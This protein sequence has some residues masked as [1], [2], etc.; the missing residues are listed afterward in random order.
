MKKI[1]AVILSGVFIF[2]LC[3]CKNKVENERFSEGS[4]IIT[5]DNLPKIAVTEANLNIAVNLVSA[6]L[7]CDVKD[8]ESLVFVCKTPDECYRKLAT[9]ESEIVIAHEPSGKTLEFLAQEQVI[10]QSSVI[11]NDA[12]VFT[13]SAQNPVSNLTIEQIKGIYSGEVTDWSSVS[14]NQG[15]IKPFMQGENSAAADAFNGCLNVDTSSLAKFFKSITT[16][17]GTFSIPLEF[18]NG[19]FSIGYAL[20]YDMLT[21]SADKNGKHKLLSVDGVLPDGSTVQSGT[22]PLLTDIVVAT[23]QN[24]GSTAKLFYEWILSEQGMRIIANS[25]VIL[26]VR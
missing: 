5:A 23:N 3:S 26:N 21:Q 2:A 24:N 13:V 9:G 18:D 20:Y 1:I 25:G 4:I 17:E 19:E 16:K 15:T 22:Y 6:V 11:A 12:L 7:G 8:A 14:G 10:L